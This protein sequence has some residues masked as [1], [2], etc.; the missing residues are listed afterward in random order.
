[1]KIIV[2]S[3]PNSKLE[4]VELVKQSELGLIDQRTGRQN[5]MP[6][7]QVWVKEMPIHGQANIAITKAL[8]KHFK[9]S[10]SMIKQI[11]GA[12]SKQKIFEINL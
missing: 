7:Y 3:K 6:I 11:S 2:K 5:S 12:S 9:I 4:K 1:M 10:L 8:A